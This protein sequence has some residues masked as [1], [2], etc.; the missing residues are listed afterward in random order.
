MLLCL[1]GA[2]SIA[3]KQKTPKRCVYVDNLGLI[4]DCRNIFNVI[5]HCSRSQHYWKEGNSQSHPWRLLIRWFLKLCIARL[6]GF[7]QW[8]YGTANWYLTHFA[9][10]VAIN[11]SNTSLLSHWNTGL[12]PACSNF[13]YTVLYAANK[14]SP[15]CS[16]APVTRMSFES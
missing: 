12:I 6:A 2:N 16:F 10:I 15:F 13:L 4:L 9:V 8:L 5:S 7:K 11:T 1:K 14:C 3:L